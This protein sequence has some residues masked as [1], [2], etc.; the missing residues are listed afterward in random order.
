MELFES[1]LR[2][3]GMGFRR[4]ESGGY[5][6]WCENQ[7]V[8]VSVDNLGRDLVGDDTDVQRVAFFVDQI[9]ASVEPRTVTPDQ[10]YW[11]LEP[12]G[13]E[14][15]TDYRSVVSPEVDRVLTAVNGDGSSLS[16]VGPGDLESMSLSPDQASDRAWANLDAELRRSRVETH[17]VDGVPV[18][19]LGT[20][21]PS[22]AS[23]ILAPCLRDVVSHILG[24]PVLAVLPDREFIYLWSAERRDFLSRV[25]DV[26][27]REYGRA[28]YPL[29]TEVFEIDVAMQA[30]GAFSA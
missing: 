13:Y 23:L 4:D 18:A 21:F 15:A 5:Q 22:K 10:L 14:H 1:E 3:R 11:C 29:T 20:S 17:D 6:V 12:N 16:W 27:V 9:V 26:V 28:S 25:G 8:L 30:I 2:R 7:S 24:W 19:M